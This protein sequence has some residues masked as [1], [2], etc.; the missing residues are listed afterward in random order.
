VNKYVPTVHILQGELGVFKPYRKYLHTYLCMYV[1]YACSMC[2][3]VT[4]IYKY[5]VVD[6]R[7]VQ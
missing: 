5:I 4:Y 6:G 3:I 7:Y 2:S 1:L